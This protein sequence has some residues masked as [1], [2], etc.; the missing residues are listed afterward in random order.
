[1]RTLQLS[2]CLSLTSEW[3]ILYLP[4]IF[5]LQQFLLLNRGKERYLCC[6]N[7][8]QRTRISVLPPIAKKK[9]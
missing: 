4:V 6:L 1:M 3:Q 2:F 8:L 9:E 5:L 7:K